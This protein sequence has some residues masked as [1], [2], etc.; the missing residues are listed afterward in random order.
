M[1]RIANDLLHQLGMLSLYRREVECQNIGEQASH[2]LRRL[3]D[4]FS[5]QR[6]RLQKTMGLRVPRHSKACPK[7]FSLAP[8][9][10]RSTPG[11]AEI[12]R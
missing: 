12:S 11:A 8:A 6:T 7:T 2:L 1:A 10:K 3:L 5:L 9:G 4:L